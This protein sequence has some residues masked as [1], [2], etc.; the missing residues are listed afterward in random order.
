MKRGRAALISFLLLDSALS[1]AGKKAPAGPSPSRLEDLI[2]QS[3]V[4]PEGRSASASPGSMWS[5]VS[6]FG[7]LARDPR[8]SQVDD[9]ITV[10]VSDKA[11]AVAK[12]GT[13]TSRKSSA[14]HSIGSIFVAIRVSR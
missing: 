11:S 10:V 1:W 5:P 2:L 8:A 14:K 9:L 13:T 12:G 3:Q 6:S 7:D 4:Q